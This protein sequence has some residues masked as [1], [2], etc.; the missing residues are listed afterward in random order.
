MK[1]VVQVKEILQFWIIFKAKEIS[2]IS[3]DKNEYAFCTTCTNLSLS[4]LD[5][6]APYSG[7]GFHELK[8]PLPYLRTT[9][10]GKFISLLK[11]IGCRTH[12]Q[13]VPGKNSRESR[14]ILGSINVTAIFAGGTNVNDIHVLTEGSSQGIVGR[15]LTTKCD[16]IHN[17]GNYL[18]L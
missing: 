13:Y 9:S 15:N 5:E 6:G 17:N 1:L 4:S 18:K 7:I 16:I 11:A 10:N 8:L 12:L 3:N 2:Y 14:C